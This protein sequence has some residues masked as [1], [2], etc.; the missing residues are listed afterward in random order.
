[1][2]HRE[3]EGKYAYY[4]ASRR[5]EGCEYLRKV[6]AHI[7]TRICVDAVYVCVCV[8]REYTRRRLYSSSAW[9]DATQRAATHAD[10]GQ[11]ERVARAYAC[12]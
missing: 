1:M 3:R 4:D 10:L 5:I 9:R 12:L 11:R 8:S 6:K 2:T 7:H